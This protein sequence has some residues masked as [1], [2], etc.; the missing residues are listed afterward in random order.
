MRSILLVPVKATE[1]PARCRLIQENLLKTR[2]LFDSSHHTYSVHSQ[3]ILCAL[4]M[5]SIRRFDQ[6][7]AIGACPRWAESFGATSNRWIG[8]IRAAVRRA[9]IPMIGLQPERSF[10]G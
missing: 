9:L 5:E 3:Y 10:G 6:I 4:S 1:G 7:T 8:S 2:L